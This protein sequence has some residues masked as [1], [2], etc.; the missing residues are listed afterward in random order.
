MDDHY[1][2]KRLWLQKD[3]KAYQD[4]SELMQK[5]SLHTDESLDYTLGVYDDEVL[6]ATASFSKDVIKCVAI[7]SCYRSE[8]LLTTLVTKLLEEMTTRGI[9]HSFLYTQ[10]EKEPIFH[11]L[12]FRKIIA[13]PEVLFMEQGVPDFTAYLELLKKYQQIGKN[14]AIVMNANPFTKGHRYLVATAAKQNE[15]VYVFVLSEELSEFSSAERMSLVKQGVAHL[16]NVT[17]LPTQQYLVSQAT[18]PAYFL[19]DKAELSIAKTQAAL[20]AHLFKERI[21]PILGIKKRY[22]GEEPYSPVTEVY[23]QAMQQVFD[24]QLDLVIV[25]RKEVSGDII[26]ATKVRQAIKDKNLVKLRDFLPKTSYDYIVKKFK[27]R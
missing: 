22:V 11:S 3:H 4:W 9:D 5:A 24:G 8:N 26:S 6:I 23:N 27:M 18:F 7:C 14:A 2:I 10:P 15:H 25:P 17:V 16:A 19:K 1:L 21:A 12:G 20:D 13:T